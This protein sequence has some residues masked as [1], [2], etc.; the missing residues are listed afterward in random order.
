M[1]ESISNEFITLLL[2]TDQEVQSACINNIHH[3]LKYLNENNK[4]RVFSS[5]LTLSTS[6]NVHIRAILAQSI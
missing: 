2:D 4:D 6:T 1:R 3:V 5:L